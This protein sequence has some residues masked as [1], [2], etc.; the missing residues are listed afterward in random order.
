MGEHN[1]YGHDVHECIKKKAY[2]LWEKDGCPQGRDEE[3]WLMAEKHMHIHAVT[4]E[5]KQN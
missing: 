4:Q 2:E 1:C 3:Y 5:H